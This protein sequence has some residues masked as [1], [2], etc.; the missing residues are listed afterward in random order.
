MMGEVGIPAWI[1]ENPAFFFFDG[2]SGNVWR[3]LESRANR[4]PANSR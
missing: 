3:W 1:L 2:E 4:S